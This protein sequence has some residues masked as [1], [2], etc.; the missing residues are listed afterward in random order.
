[1]SWRKYT[2]YCSNGARFHLE[3]YERHEYIFFA[4]ADDI[5]KRIFMN[6]NIIYI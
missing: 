1:M 3:N 6:E 2:L 4:W 5:F